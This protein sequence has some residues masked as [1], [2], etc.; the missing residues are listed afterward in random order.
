MNASY[1]LGRAKEV[2]TEILALLYALIDINDLQGVLLIGAKPEQAKMSDHDPPMSS[3]WHPDFNDLGQK[4]TVVSLPGV[5]TMEFRKDKC[6]LL[7]VCVQRFSAIEEMLRD[8]WQ[9]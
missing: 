9:H 8:R 3:G 4:I 2:A 1:F 5:T 7:S 6:P